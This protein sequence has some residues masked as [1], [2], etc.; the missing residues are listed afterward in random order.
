MMKSDWR[1]VR[2]HDPY[3]GRLNK[4]IGSNAR[5]GLTQN[6]RLK[7]QNQQE[8]Y[9]RLGISIATSSKVSLHSSSKRRT[10]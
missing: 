6:P 10:L 3:K 7:S 4:K 9:S 2:N 5:A 8:S 1:G